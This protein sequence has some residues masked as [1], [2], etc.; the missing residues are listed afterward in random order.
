MPETTSDDR[1]KRPVDSSARPADQR[2][3]RRETERNLVVGG[4][5][6]ALV[7]GGGLIWLFWDLRAMLTSWLC[8]GSV[9]V[10]IGAIYLALKL[11]ERVGRGG[12]DD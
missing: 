2:R 1:E 8:L 7:V 4:I 10:P 6:V 12:R 9:V 11:M 5:A 3:L